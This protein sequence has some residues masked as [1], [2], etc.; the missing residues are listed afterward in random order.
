NGCLVLRRRSHCVDTSLAIGYDEGAGGR[1]GGVRGRTR[2]RCAGRTR[3][4]LVRSA[5][6]WAPVPGAAAR[7]W[8]AGP[9]AERCARPGGGEV[10]AARRPGRVV[11]AAA[12]ARAATGAHWRL[13]AHTG[14]QTTTDATAKEVRS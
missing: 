6:R 13:R 3:A 7:P 4:G 1:T 10:V 5:R 14:A 9:V 2:S 11:G 12:R 8:G